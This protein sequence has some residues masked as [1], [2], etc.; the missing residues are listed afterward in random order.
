MIQ[1]L[2]LLVQASG[3]AAPTTVPASKF[4]P[5]TLSAR[6]PHFR[7]SPLLVEGRQK[8]VDSRY[9][10]SED[11]PSRNWYG[12]ANACRLHRFSTRIAAKC[13]RQNKFGPCTLSAHAPHF[14][15]S[16]LL[17]EGRQYAL[18]CI[19]IDV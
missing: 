16:P 17:V 13:C 5:Y 11:T 18:Y 6:A 3:N 10:T 1:G 9:M 19:V 15:R 8:W 7:R 2:H 4:G 14:R 12:G